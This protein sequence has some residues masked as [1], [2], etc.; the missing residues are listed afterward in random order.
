MYNVL[1]VDDEVDTLYSLQASLDWSALG[2]DKL[3][4]ADG[5]AKAQELLERYTVHLMICD[6]EMPGMDGLQLWGWVRERFPDT[7]GIFLT[8]HADFSYAQQAIALGGR[9]YLLKP[10]DP[11]KLAEELEK[12]F[13]AIAERSAT[14]KNSVLWQENLAMR[15]RDYLFNVINRQLAT[16]EA[17]LQRLSEE[18]ELDFAPGMQILPVLLLVQQWHREMPPE[19]IPLMEY[20]ICNTATE[21]FVKDEQAGDVLRL[22]KGHVLVLLYL[23]AD[24][25]LRL[26][27]EGACKEQ[28]D[29][30]YRY[31]T[32]D[33]SCL[34]GR[35]CTVGQLADAVEELTDYA[36]R[37]AVHHL[38]VYHL[39]QTAA[40]GAG[41]QV[42]DP[43]DWPALLQAGEGSAVY[44]RIAAW[45]QTAGQNGTA[46]VELLQRIQ[47]DFLQAVYGVLQ[48]NNIQANLLFQDKHSF[49]MQEKSLYSIEHF[50]AWLQWTLRRAGDCLNRLTNADTVVVRVKKYI[51]ANIKNEELNREAIANAVYLNPDYLSRLFK[52]KTGVSLSEYIQQQRLTLAKNLLTQT[53]LSVGDIAFNLGYSSFSYFT[54]VFKAA[55]GYAPMEYRKTFTKQ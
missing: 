4:L 47:Q 53:R 37:K 51:A 52:Q 45:L 29:L 19:D 10:A 24:G 15:R 9:N 32:A 22:S 38:Q 3:L 11:D 28:V 54:R 49:L 41:P 40:S 16:G 1:L 12:A 36:R 44:D 35:A 23:P 25:R 46:D 13:A 55:T 6:I 39:A 43:A 14:R 2:V 31:L 17:A 42:P 48:D 18:R 20:G 27:L 34:I 30:C 50:L 26:S 21:I 33:L 8:C 7:E 5:A